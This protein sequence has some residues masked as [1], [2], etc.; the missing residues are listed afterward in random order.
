MRILKCRFWLFLLFPI[1]LFSQNNVQKID[2]ES[3]ESKVNTS[4]FD[5]LVKRYNDSDLSLTE[6]DLQQLY[7]GY[8]L[9]YSYNNNPFFR[10]ENFNLLENDSINC[11]I[12]MKIC[13]SILKD[14]LFDLEVK[15]IQLGCKKELI[16]KTNNYINEVNLVI[17]MLFAI[18]NSGL[19]TLQSPIY[20]IN[21]NHKNF[22]LQ[23]LQ[24]KTTGKISYMNS[25]EVVQIIDDKSIKEIYFDIS[26][27][28]N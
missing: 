27:T 11:S 28:L 20:I 23:I 9:K 8:K 24:L 25:L 1:I 17:K 12:K 15:I 6:S 5:D 2:F 26:K 4:D 3:I 18:K 16:P 13:D 10:N 7:Y 19:G 22:I 21:T 14:D